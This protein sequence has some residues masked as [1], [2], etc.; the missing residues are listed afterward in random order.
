MS[1][2]TNMSFYSDPKYYPKFG[3][4]D[5]GRQ[6]TQ[7]VDGRIHRVARLQPPGRFHP[8]CDAGRTAAGNDVAG[9]Q[10]H[11]GPPGDQFRGLV[12]HLPGIGVLAQFAVDAQF[13][14]QVVGI[15]QLIQRDQPGTQ[16]T[17]TLETLPH[18]DHLVRMLPGLDVPGG[19]VIENGIT[20]HVVEG[21]FRHRP[22]RPPCR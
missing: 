1:E 20:R 12:V 10:A 15:V 2:I 18:Q 9:I 16:G 13:H 17:G 3:L 21:L 4:Y 8:G 7:S 22:C 6:C 11:V 14:I 19:Q 5:P